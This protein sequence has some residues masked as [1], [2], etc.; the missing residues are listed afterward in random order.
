MSR[1]RRCNRQTFLT[2]VLQN[3]IV[4][5]NLWYCGDLPIFWG[6]PRLCQR[7]CSHCEIPCTVCGHWKQMQQNYNIKCPSDC[8]SAIDEPHISHL[9]ITRMSHSLKRRTWVQRNVNVHCNNNNNNNRTIYNN[10]SYKNNNTVSSKD[11]WH[12]ENSTSEHTEKSPIKFTSLEDEQ[13]K[14]LIPSYSCYQCQ[15][16]RNI[17]TQ[18]DGERH[19]NINPV[20]SFCTYFPQ[21][22]DMRKAIGPLVEADW[23]ARPRPCKVYTHTCTSGGKHDGPQRHRLTVSS[24]SRTYK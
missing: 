22:S 18:G 12:E 4:Y 10:N 3:F 9:N 23:T 24:V 6:Q 11:V 5:I 20:F 13:K 7:S 15:P 21:T 1:P 8:C 17:Q 16:S 19:T 2:F 14:I